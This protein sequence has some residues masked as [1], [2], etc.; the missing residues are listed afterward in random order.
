M[1]E[2]ASA[3]FSMPLLEMSPN[4]QEAEGS[5]K[6]SHDEYADE[7]TVKGNGTDGI[8]KPPNRESSTPGF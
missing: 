3:H 2:T 5:R 8:A 7:A 4:V 1:I 6:R